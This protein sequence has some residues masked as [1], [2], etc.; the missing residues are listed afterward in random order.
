M[1]LFPLLFCHKDLSC[2]KDNPNMSELLNMAVRG[3]F[4]KKITG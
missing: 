1:F 3:K 4:G 2:N